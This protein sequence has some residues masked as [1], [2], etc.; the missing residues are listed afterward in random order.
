MASNSVT[1]HLAN[2]VSSWRRRDWWRV[3]VVDAC[4]HQADS[5]EPCVYMRFVLFASH[6]RIGASRYPPQTMRDGIE[7]W[8]RRPGDSRQG[9]RAFA[10]ASSFEFLR[11]NR[12]ILC[13][14][15]WT[16]PNTFF[17]KHG[18]TLSLSYRCERRAC[19]IRSLKGRNIR[20]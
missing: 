10:V 11:N 4:L 3:G 8:R 17:S 7:S 5:L 2:R 13:L 1:R 20:A 6:W 18:A 12:P 16:R 19:I 9:P 14:R 15:R